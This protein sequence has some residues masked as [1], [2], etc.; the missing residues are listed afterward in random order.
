[1]RYVVVRVRS[2]N[3]GQWIPTDRTQVI[4]TA[5]GNRVVGVP[6]HDKY[7]LWASAGDK[8]TRASWIHHLGYFLQSEGGLKDIPGQVR[9]EAVCE[10]D[11]LPIGVLLDQL[12]YVNHEGCVVGIPADE[13]ISA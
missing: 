9:I 5:K 6:A 1:M 8:G 7:L 4:E 11:Q 12:I 2:L 10:L 3:Q 13:H